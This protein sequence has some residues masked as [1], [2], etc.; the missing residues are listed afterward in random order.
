MDYFLL[1]QSYELN[2][3]S[4]QDSLET[5]EDVSKYDYYVR[6]YQ[7]MLVILKMNIEPPLK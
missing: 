2:C 3:I 4:S 7:A 6:V 5:L 1:S